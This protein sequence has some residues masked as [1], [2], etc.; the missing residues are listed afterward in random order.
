TTTGK[1][2]RHYFISGDYTW[3][4]DEDN[5]L[6]PNGRIQF[7]PNL[8]VDMEGG[9]RLEHKDLIWIGFNYHYRQNYTAF[10]G[11]KF[12]HMLAI[13]YAYDVYYSPLTA[14]DEGGAAH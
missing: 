12:N 3:K 8:P 2:Y 14:F 6:V 7:V 4:V 11:V 13:G 9:V 1:L 5:V 10:A